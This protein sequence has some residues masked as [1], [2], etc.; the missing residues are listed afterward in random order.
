MGIK[1]TTPQGAFEAFFKKAFQI[2]KDEIFMAFAKLG[3]ESIR[4][5]LHEGMH[6]NNVFFPPLIKGALTVQIRYRDSKKNFDV[7]SADIL[8]GTLRRYLIRSETFQEA[9]GRIAR[10]ADVIEIIPA[11]K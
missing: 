1:V 11:Q 6:H 7:Q 2:I 8:A 10:I 3:E 5:E 9:L 4:K